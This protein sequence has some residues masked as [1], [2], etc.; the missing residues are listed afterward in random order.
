VDLAGAENSID[1]VL[2]RDGAR[3]VVGPRIER[4]R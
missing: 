2:A 4:R 1:I 3:I